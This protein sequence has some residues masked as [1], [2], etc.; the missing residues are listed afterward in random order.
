MAT[1]FTTVGRLLSVPARSA[2]VSAL[3][4][5]RALTVGE[6]ARVAG[7]SASTASEH[8]TSLDAGGLVRVLRQGRHRY[9]ALSGP[10]V[11]AALEALALVSPPVPVTSLRQSRD[12]RALRAAR[13]CYD[14]LAGELG[15]RVH[16]ALVRQGWVATDPAYLLTDTGAGELRALGVDVDRAVAGRGPVVRPCLDW[17]ERRYHLAGALAGEVA[18]TF[19]ERDW[20]RRTQGRGLRLTPAG[21]ELLRQCLDPSEPAPARA[22]A[23]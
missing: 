3:L 6:L 23:R 8:V 19:L 5:G 22:T 20:V 9:V 2:M 1:D 12:A 21:E 7:V 15:V 14:H 16:D 18:R 13:T 17:T 4:E 10:Q 11:A